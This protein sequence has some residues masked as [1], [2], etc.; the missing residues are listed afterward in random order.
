MKPFLD[1]A[2][3]KEIDR[4]LKTGLLDGITTNPTIL[5]NA[6]VTE[7]M[8]A[9]KQIV[10]LIR[11]YTPIPISLSVEVFSDSPDEMLKQAKSFVNELDY[12]GTT[13][14]IPILGTDG[15]DRLAVIRELA[16]QEIAV[17][18]T[19]CITWFQAFAAAKAGAKYVSLLYRRIMDTGLDGSAEIRKTRELIDQYRLPSEIIVGSIRK[20]NDVLRAYEAGAHIVTIPTKFLPELLMNKMSVKT[21]KQF[22]KDA[23]VLKE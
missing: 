1:T 3:L 14:K 5:K 20:K 23:G 6:G 4:W 19:A 9:W 10:E 2:D 7:P 18:C 8:T 12:E 17:N 11:K 15:T 16:Q 21:Q 13:I 22:L